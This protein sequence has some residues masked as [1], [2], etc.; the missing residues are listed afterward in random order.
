MYKAVFLDMDGTLLRSDHSVSEATQRTIRMLTRRGT[1]VILVSA[2]PVDAVLPT[3]REIGIPAEYPIISLN[4]SYVVEKDQPIFQA[5]IDPGTVVDVAAHVRPF[6]ATI[7]YYV[8]REWYAEVDDAW[9]EHEQKIMDIKLKVMTLGQ[10]EEEWKARNISPNKMMVMSEPPAILEI[11][12]H[13]R[14]IYDGRLNIYPSKATYLEVMDKAGSKSHAV[15]FVS[16]R[17]GLAAKEIVAMGDN[18]NDIGMIR[19]AGMGVAM[20]NAPD[21][22]KKNAKYVTDTNN[23]DGVRKALEKFFE[24]EPAR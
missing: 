22:I 8:Q 9:T 16:E 2:R 12:Q 19:F 10:M 24:L 15:K 5:E 13:L 11:Q 23:D 1:P 17:M 3:S 14:S 4:G 21:D 7:A 20:G 6:Q 18:Y